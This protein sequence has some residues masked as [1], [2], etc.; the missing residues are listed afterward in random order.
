MP[1]NASCSNGF[2]YMFHGNQTH[3]TITL[4]HTQ[5]GDLNRFKSGRIWP[6]VV[7]QRRVRLARDRFKDGGRLIAGANV[8]FSAGLFVYSSTRLASAAQAISRL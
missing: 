5:E 3:F 1:D 6:E 7:G 8:V 2:V 4:P